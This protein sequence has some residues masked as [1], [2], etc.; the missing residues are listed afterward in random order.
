V[1]ALETLSFLETL[2]RAPAPIQVKA[3]C[4]AEDLDLKPLARS[5]F[6][7]RGPLVLKA[8]VAGCSVLFRYGAVVLFNLSGAEESAFLAS[9]QPLL[10]QP[11]PQPV[12]ET[13]ILTVLPQQREGIES[14]QLNLSLLDLPRLQVIGDILAKTVVLEHYEGQMT[15]AFSQVERL[16][17]SIALSQLK[18][19]GSSEMLK[20]IGGSLLVQQKMLGLVEISEKPDLLWDHPELER[21]YIRLEDE[22]ELRER[23]AVLERKLGLITR[24]AETALQ[25]IQHGTSERL[26]WYIILLIVVEILLSVYDLFLRHP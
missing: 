20:P 6:L 4:L 23:A 10:R 14:D 17:E 26:E 21:F 15:A 24:T 22:Y 7:A 8:G 19:P 12:Q 16:A 11:F 1:T 2:S 5:D 3:L 25:L 18:P 9:L 13:V